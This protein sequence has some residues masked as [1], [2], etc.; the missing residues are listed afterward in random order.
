[1]RRD[2]R[3]GMAPVI[4]AGLLSMLTFSTA[5]QAGA[6]YVDAGAMTLSG[7]TQLR[8]RAPNINQFSAGNLNLGLNVGFG[9]FVIDGLEL[10][11]QLTSAI[12]FLNNA[13]SSNAKYP[14]GNDKATRSIGIGP[15]LTYFF[16]TGS[17]A[18]PHLGG[19]FTIDWLYRYS[20]IAKE[21]GSLW[22]VGLKPSFGV[23]VALNKYVALDFGLD[24]LF[25]IPLSGEPVTPP[26]NATYQYNYSFDGSAGYAG[27]LVFF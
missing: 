27:V 25:K 20:E 23:A 5:S 2:K 3:L 22:S 26:P 11:F 1:M 24:V 6:L 8:Y 16:E 17:I 10:G 12:G 15:S 7:Q 13:P 21:M 4:L 18:Y 14:A 9:Y 19:L